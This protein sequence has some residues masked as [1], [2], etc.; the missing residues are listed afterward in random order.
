MDLEVDKLKQLRKI[1]GETSLKRKIVAAFVASSI[2]PALVIVYFSYLNT[3]KIV[4]NNVE[5]LTHSNLIQVSNSVDVWMKSYEDILFQIYMNDEIVDMVYDINKEIDVTNNVRLLR[6]TIRGMFY[7]KEYIKSIT[8]ITDNGTIIFYDLLTGANM[9]SSWMDS[10]GMSTSDL[11][12]EVS[13]DNNTHLLS[14]KEAGVYASEKYYLFHMGHRIIDYKNLDNQLGI[15]IVSIDENMIKDIYR[16]DKSENG[17][18]FITDT[19]GDIVSSNEE[20][21]LSK[22]IIEWSDDIEIRKQRYLEYWKTVP[23]YK[24]SK[25]SVDVVFDEKTNWDIVRVFNKDTVMKKL[26][27]QQ[28]FILIGISF[29]FIIMVALSIMLSN[30]LMYSINKLVQIIKRVGKGELSAR[31]EDDAK[32]PTEI[33]MIGSQFNSTL[34]KLVES[35]EKEKEAH[36]SQKNAEIAALEAQINPHFLYNTLDTINWMAIDRDEFE[37]SN[38]ITSLAKILRYGIDNSNGI[39]TVK[40][41][42]E[43]LQQ[44]LYLQQTRLK[45]TF[46]CEISISPEIMKW[47]IHKLLLQPFIENSILHGFEGKK[48]THCLKVSMKPIEG[49]LYIEIWD[50]GNGMADDIIAQLNQGEYIRTEEKNCIGMENAITRIQMYYGK[51]AKVNIE[52]ELGKYTRIIIFIPDMDSEE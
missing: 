3:S 22:K 44:Y 38:S 46:Q 13:A 4:Q 29:A 36:D 30:N 12:Q 19:N 15:I 26:S 21:L 32:I 25:I 27:G 28:S 34:D 5:E 1:F 47:E 10:F 51:R 8:I 35:M 48:G 6:K 9:Q 40:M 50:N 52:S 7:T 23:E 16:G 20:D 45:N 31:A 18:N 39:T 33:R 42:Y 2:L 41:E 49:N 11:Y 14:T 24:Y 43:W 17:F 37:I